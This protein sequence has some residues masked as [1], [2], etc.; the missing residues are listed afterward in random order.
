MNQRGKVITQRDIAVKAGVTTA[1][2]SLALRNSPQVSEAKRREI[3]KIAEELGYRP[4]PIATRLVSRRKRENAQTY[5]AALAW[6]NL[7]PEP[8]ALR[9]YP[10]FE[11][12]WQGALECAEKHGYRLEE[13]CLAETSP[14]R[15]E[16]I[17]YARGI[18]GVILTAHFSYSPV[19]L[20]GIHWEKF[21][22]VRTSRF[23]VSP[24]FH[25]VTPHQFSNTILAFD[26]IRAKGYR[27]VGLIAYEKSPGGRNWEFESG[28]LAAQQEIPTRERL[29]IFHLD[30]SDSA[31]ESRLDA[32]IKRQRPDAIL[33][34]HEQAK[35]YLLN[36][37]YR[38]P[39]DF[40]LATVSRQDCGIEAGIDQLATEI[41]RCA[42]LLLLSMLNDNERGLPQHT[43]E[44]LIKG[45]WVDGSSLPVR[46]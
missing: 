6:L 43:R 29:P 22:A 14:Q 17:L 45:E 8:R 23:P 24:G 28:F 15:I 33:T 3:Q 46:H 30:S 31:S 10:L 34:V 38:I 7:W 41:G 1:A 32:W 40:G 25:L 12:Y 37:G 44:V 16:S 2:V 11:G 9:K 42:V 35:T 36:L 39:E 19:D 18:E 4:D 20:G 26:R 21:S 13:I 5:H 27:R